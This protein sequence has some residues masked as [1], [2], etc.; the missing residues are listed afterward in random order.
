[1]DLLNFTSPGS[2]TPLRASGAALL[3]DRERYEIVRDIPRFVS[4]DNYAR[5]FGLQWNLFK[6]TQFDSCTGTNVTEKR[7]EEALGRPLTA[8]R[9][10]KVLEAGCGSGRFTEILLKYGA[11]VYSFDYSNAIDANY[12]N[13]MPNADLTLFQADI[14]HIPFH[15][16]FFDFVICLGVLQ[17]TPS[18]S[19]SVAELTRV[20]NVNGTILCD[21]YP[22]HPGLFTSLYIPYWLFIKSLPVDRQLRVT[23]A[24]TR[25][26]FPIHWR[27][28]AN[29]LAQ[30]LLRRISPISF[31]YGLWDLPK[32][33]HYEW[34]RLDTHDR[35]T[36]H[37]KRHLTKG[38]FEHI[39]QKLGYSAVNV[40]RGGT[41]LV[42]RAQK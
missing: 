8:L 42:A 16:G 36:D 11:R 24:L 18:T 25:W 17:H 26:F 34:T 5:A 6:T 19:Q 2:D 30:I 23:D 1:M 35:N 7:L 28:R 20:L 4:S 14:R 22:M 21:H 38:R 13:N 10:K 12:E 33:V 32:D 31:F 27:F 3:G 39:F 29:G 37:F 15:A 9:G 40:F 41:G